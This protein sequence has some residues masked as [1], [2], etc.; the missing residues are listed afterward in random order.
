[1]A[2]PRGA[3]PLD[4]VEVLRAAVDLVLER[5]D[6]GGTLWRSPLRALAGQ[7]PAYERASGHDPG[8]L[9][10]AERD[11]LPLL[12]AQQRRR[13]EP[14]RACP[15]SLRLDQRAVGVMLVFMRKRLS[16]SQAV[17]TCTSR[18]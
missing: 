17:L 10:V 6:P 5:V 8:T 16:G 2:L 1:V 7:K 4:G 11:H 18:S 12:L 3:E 13:F 14:G 15:V 9:V